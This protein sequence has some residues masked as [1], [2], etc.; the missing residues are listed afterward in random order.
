MDVVLGELLELHLGQAYDLYW[1]RH[2]ACPSEEEYLE[3]TA[4]SK[5][6]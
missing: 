3:M 2:A 6:F 5:C 4:K 1:T